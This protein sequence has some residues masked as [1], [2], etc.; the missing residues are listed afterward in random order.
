ML[1]RGCRGNA[2]RELQNDLRELG[3]MEEAATGYFGTKTQE[4]LKRFQ[5][6]YGLLTDGIFGEKSKN[7]IKKAISLRGEESDE[8]P[9]SVDLIKKLVPQA[10]KENIDRYGP[11]I[12]EALKRH[13]LDYIEMF[14]MVIGTIYA[15]VGNRFEPISEYISKYNTKPGGR[16]FALYD[17]RTELGNYSVGD[18]ERFKGRGFVQLTGKFNYKKYG[19]IVS[20]NLGKKI[21][22]I[23]EPELANNPEIASEI[24]VCFLKDREAD[25]VSAIQDKNL[26]K[27]RKLVNGGTH[28]L[29]LFSSVFK[30][31]EKLK[32]EGGFDVK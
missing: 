20:N 27:A 17:F 8:I 21:N 19:E 1:K 6:D 12:L 30:Q 22:L 15:E 32:N 2:V 10:N 18:G 7:A 4:A 31:Y 11:M 25:I 29:D 5:K 23:E 9:P 28:G 3:Y 24:L 13:G 26:N 14:L 16:P